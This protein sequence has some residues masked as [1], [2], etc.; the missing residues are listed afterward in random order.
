MD[1]EQVTETQPEPEKK[2][3]TFNDICLGVLG[4]IVILSLLALP[5]LYLVNFLLPVLGSDR[6]FD[7]QHSLAFA[8][9]LFF[10]GRCISPAS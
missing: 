9:L 10:M 5:I 3:L 2:P 7:Y 8:F 4:I 1:N 6:Q